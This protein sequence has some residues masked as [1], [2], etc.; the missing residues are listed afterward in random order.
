MVMARTMTIL[1][2]LGWL[3]RDCGS[4]RWWRPCR[5]CAAIAKKLAEWKHMERDLMTDMTNR[6]TQGWE[7]AV[8]DGAREI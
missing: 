8:L 7:R 2:R 4:L 5:T 1:A 6:Q 3:C